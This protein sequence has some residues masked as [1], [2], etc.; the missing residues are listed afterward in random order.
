MAGKLIT[1]LV[2]FVVAA[3]LAC[4]PAV[5]ARWSVLDSVQLPDVVSDGVVVI[6]TCGIGGSSNKGIVASAQQTDEPEFSRIR[7][8]W[9]ADKEHARWISVDAAT[10]HCWNEAAG[11]S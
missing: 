4:A 8:A 2:S 9:L 3:L 7:A 6:E 5:A 11:S 1:G 10:V